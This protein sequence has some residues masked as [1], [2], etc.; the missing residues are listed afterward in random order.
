M[1]TL[2]LS[3]ICVNKNGRALLSGINLELSGNTMVG[4]IGPN[5]AGKSTLLRVM[6]GLQ[7][8]D[9]GHVKLFGQTLKSLQKKNLGR[10]LAYLPQS[11]D[12]AWPLKVEKIVALGRLPHSATR[13][14]L[15]RDDTKIIAQVMHDTDIEH[16]TGR[17]LNTLSGGEK[18]RVM[19]A[20]TLASE[21]QI[22]LAD[23][24]IASLDPLHQ[25]EVMELLANIAKRG[26]TVVVVLHELNLAMRFCDRLALLHGGKLLAS[27]E[28]QKA[29]NPA[30]LRQAYLIEAEYGERGGRPWIIPWAKRQR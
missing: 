18:M 15:S 13:T 10:Q 26:T 20:R 11:A 19:L 9:P 17:T 16:L 1:N 5:G 8:V 23:E 3:N 30:L 12:C 24:P 14:K 21:P 2:S 27:G 6:A 22:L 25:L 29:L 4:L 7:V 28:P